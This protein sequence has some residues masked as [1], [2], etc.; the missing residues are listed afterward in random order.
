MLKWIKENKILLLT[1]IKFIGIFFLSLIMTVSVF[2][3]VKWREELLGNLVKYLA[4]PILIFSCFYLIKD[5]LIKLIERIKKAKTP[6]GEFELDTTQEEINSLFKGDGE[7][8][9]ENYMPM[10]YLLA[11]YIIFDIKGNDDNIDNKMSISL[12]NHCYNH[13]QKNNF[14][15]SKLSD[16]IIA[17]D[18]Y[19]KKMESE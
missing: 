7:V 13:L 2:L 11:G 1:I 14:D 12:F 5:P 19:I 15:K 18:K 16:L 17:R 10:I 6:F 3:M 4:Y 8:N 9:K